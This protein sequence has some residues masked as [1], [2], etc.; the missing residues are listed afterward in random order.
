MVLS[1]VGLNRQKEFDKVA[2][3]LLIC[4]SFL[5]K[6][7]VSNKIRQE[8]NVRG[9]KLFGKEIMLSQ[10]ADDTSLFNADIESL[11]RTLKIVG[12]SEE[13]LVCS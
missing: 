6:Y 5:R 12:I 10:F 8:P 3:S 4:L 1:P 13:L 11:E 2:L 7:S 9:I